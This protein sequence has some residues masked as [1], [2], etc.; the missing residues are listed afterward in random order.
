[1]QSVSKLMEHRLRLVPSEERR[2]PLG[3]LGIIADII[4]ERQ[5]LAVAA[6]F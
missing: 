6:L 3:R 1:M 4:D 2:L 5:L